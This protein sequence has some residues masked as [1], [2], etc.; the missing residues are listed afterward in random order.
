[1]TIPLAFLSTLYR[2][3][4]DKITMQICDFRLIFLGTAED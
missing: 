4:V 1:M 2:A 3:G